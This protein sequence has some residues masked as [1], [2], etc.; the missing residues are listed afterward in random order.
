MA[1][2]RLHCFDFALI[3]P[4]LQRRIADSEHLG[5][6]TRREQFRGFHTR[7]AHIR[8]DASLEGPYLSILSLPKAP[9]SSCVRSKLKGPVFVVSEL[10]G[11]PLFTRRRRGC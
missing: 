5:R 11:P 10:S 4:L 1:A 6:F 2:S 9:R 3:D 8:M 7:S